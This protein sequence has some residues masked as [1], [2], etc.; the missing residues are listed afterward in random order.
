MAATVANQEIVSRGTYTMKYAEITLDSAYLTDGEAI[1]AATFG[2]AVI[3]LIIIQDDPAGY[4]IESVRT[5]DDSWKIK[6]YSF[7]NTTN[8]VLGNIV[9]GKDLSAVTIRCLVVG[10]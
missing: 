3:K 10:R 9:S 5:D 8:T 4:T 2:F 6:V 1:E 7:S